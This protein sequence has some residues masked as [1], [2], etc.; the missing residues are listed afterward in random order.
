[1]K[2]VGSTCNAVGVKLLSNVYSSRINGTFNGWDGNS[3]YTLTNGQTWQQA[4]WYWYWS[5][6]YRPEVLVYYDSGW[7][8]KVDDLKAVSVRRIYGW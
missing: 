3:M 1:M 7:K 8:M 2:V 5:W 4:S 6:K